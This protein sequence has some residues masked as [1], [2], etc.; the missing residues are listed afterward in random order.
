MKWRILD[1]EWLESQIGKMYI[2]IKQFIIYIN[3]LQSLVLYNYIMF[4]QYKISDT[5][6][7]VALNIQTHFVSTRLI[8]DMSSESFK[9]LISD[10]IKQTQNVILQKTPKYQVLTLFKIRPQNCYQFSWILLLVINLLFLT[11]LYLFQQAYLNNKITTM[12][13]LV[14]IQLH[15]SVLVNTKKK[16]NC[17]FTNIFTEIFLW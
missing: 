13:R 12:S 6:Y 7:E 17:F 2:Q 16:S 4:V 8:K 9:F 10:I 5:S 3:Y 14:S 11:E 1:I 15:H